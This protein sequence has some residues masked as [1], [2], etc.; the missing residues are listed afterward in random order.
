MSWFAKL[1]HYHAVHEGACRDVATEA[2][3]GAINLNR[4]VGHSLGTP[5]GLRP[6][7]PKVYPRAEK[8]G[9]VDL[10]T[11]KFFGNHDAASPR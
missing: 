3:Y 9:G 7:P 8:S 10:V 1:G 6:P 5:I 11:G 2:D 4:P